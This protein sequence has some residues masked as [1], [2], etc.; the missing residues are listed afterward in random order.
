MSI[1]ADDILAATT[2]VTKE[3]T[4]QRK[5]EERNSRAYYSRDYIYS[6]RVN[7][8]EVA[9]QILPRGYDH[10]SG[11]GKYTVDKRQFYY[12]VREDFRKMTGRE[13]TAK[14][15]SQ[16]ILVQ[17][18]NQ[19]LEET[20]VWK[21]TAQPRGT[22]RLPHVNLIVPCGT[23]AIDKH[24]HEVLRSLSLPDPPAGAGPEE[25]AAAIAKAKADLP[26]RGLDK[27][28]VDRRWPPLAGGHRYRGVLYIEKEGFDP[29]LRE[30]EV[31][32]EFDIAIIS[33]KGQSVVA[34]RKFADYTCYVN[35]GVPLFVVHDMD[36]AGF[37][38]ALRLTKVSD[39]A[40]E[41]DL[42]QYEFQNDID[43]TDLGLTLKDARKYN[44]ESERCRFRGSFAADSIATAEEKEFLRSNRRIELNAFTAPDFIKWIRSKLTKHLGKK[45]FVPD[46]DVLVDA[47]RRALAVAEINGCIKKVREEAITKAR[48]ATVPDDLREQLQKRL[49]RNS[50][51][52][53][54][55]LY[56]LAAGLPEKGGD[57]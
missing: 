2:K 20:V 46:D 19:H 45:R 57:K 4:K 24:L 23:L 48:A 36:K 3:W 49:T 21:I 42:V 32:E 40:I 39:Y 56:E 9:H 50:K 8:T 34:A 7:F 38:I 44:L 37:E 5:A 30:A 12:A 11:N 14:Y 18:M 10:A 6:D 16:N 52:W 17:Y 54:K 51:P 26:F 31:A 15:F 13:I 53:D 33:C 41:K 47:Y 43:V 28:G 22:L 25:V 35:G 29:Q 27:I 55:V 1:T